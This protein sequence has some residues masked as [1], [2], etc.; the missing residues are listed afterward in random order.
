MLAQLVIYLLIDKYSPNSRD[1]FLKVH[2]NF[3][4]KIVEI[5]IQDNGIGLS[6]ED[7]CHVFE[8]FFRVDKSGNVAGIGLGLSLSK[9][10][11]QLFNGDIF[12]TSIPN[13]G[14]SVFI[15]LKIYEN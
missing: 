5:E 1:I 7:C 10:I 8:R 6:K 13:E 11:M 12:I 4:Q 14:S 3:T 2:H 9:E 15:R